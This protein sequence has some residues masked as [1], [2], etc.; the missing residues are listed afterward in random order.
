MIYNKMGTNS[1]ADGRWWPVQ[2]QMF[3]AGQLRSKGQD[4]RRVRGAK[5][6][7][8]V[9]DASYELEVVVPRPWFIGSWRE[10]LQGI[11]FPIV[12]GEVSCIVINDLCCR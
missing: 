11:L 7:A 6:V 12:D 2:P 4:I 9:A 1:V 5:E 8:G 10:K 3:Q